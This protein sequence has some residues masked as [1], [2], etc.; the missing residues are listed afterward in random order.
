[1]IQNTNLPG[2]VI[3]LSKNTQ[4][5][6]AFITFEELCLLSEKVHYERIYIFTVKL[7]PCLLGIHMYNTDLNIIIDSELSVF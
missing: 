3:T 4:L 5:K 2:N 6:H 7:L 1:M